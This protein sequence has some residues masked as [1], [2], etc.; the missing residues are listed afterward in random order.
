MKRRAESEFESL[1]KSYQDVELRVQKLEALLAKSRELSNKKKQPSMKEGVR[2]LEQNVDVLNDV[3]LSDDKDQETKTTNPVDGVM[4]NI[5]SHPDD[6][7][8]LLLTVQNNICSCFGYRQDMQLLVKWSDVQ[9]TIIAKHFGPKYPDFCFLSTDLSVP[10]EVSKED[11][12][13]DDCIN[14]LI[15]NG[16]PLYNAECDNNEANGIISNLKKEKCI[17]FV[18]RFLIYRTFS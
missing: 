16:I 4:K 9:S 15:E 17:T 6:H 8:M 5:V 13:L 2:N 11:K 18:S 10:S 1:L 3:A 14:I 12:E 7:G